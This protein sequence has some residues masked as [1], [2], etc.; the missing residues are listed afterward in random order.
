MSL[1][2]KSLFSLL[3]AASLCRAGAAEQ[4]PVKKD[5]YSALARVAKL[6][7]MSAGREYT[8]PVGTGTVTGEKENFLRRR[9]PDEILAGGLSSGCGDQAAAFYGL[10]RSKGYKLLFVDAVELSVSSL[11]SKFNGHTAVAVKDAASGKW[12]LADPVAAEIISEDWDPS[13]KVYR[14]PAG[15][16]WVGY[17]GSLERYPYKT[18]ARLGA[19]YVKTLTTVPSEVRD[20]E[21]VR[22][23]FSAGPGALK[24]DG[25][26]FNPRMPAFIADYSTVYERLGLHPRRYVDVKLSARDA[27]PDSECKKT[28][29]GA[30]ECLIGGSSAL[31]GAAFSWIERDKAAGW[32]GELNLQEEKAGKAPAAG[33]ETPV[34]LLPKSGFAIRFIVDRS[35][36]KADG[37][38]LNPFLQDFLLRYGSAKGTPVHIFPNSNDIMSECSWKA[39]Q[40]NCRLGR[41]SGLGEA[42]YKIIESAALRKN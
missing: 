13:A 14:S 2:K 26:F 20:E 37:T 17:A 11:L 18:P 30:I 7:T 12:L 5:I 6:E 39:G 40:L 36:I 4:E 3:T 23:R 1:F 27:G 35:Y 34:I 25:S 21:I 41:N 33:F 24:P 28:G 42:V 38:W 31:G 8:L 9:T 19:F 10:M 32:A 15:S 16:F 29:Q 22:L